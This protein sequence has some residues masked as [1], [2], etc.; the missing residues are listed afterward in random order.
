MRIPCLVDEG[1]SYYFYKLMAK[2]T[3]E[4][5][6]NSVL[7]L[8]IAIYQRVACS[9]EVVCAELHCKSISHCYFTVVALISQ[10]E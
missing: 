2:Y 1:V 3:A 8:N 6:G 9:G 4:A 10:A 5:F 7:G